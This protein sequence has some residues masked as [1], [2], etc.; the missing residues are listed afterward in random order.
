MHVNIDCRLK[1]ARIAAVIVF[2]RRV[3][4]VLKDHLRKLLITLMVKLQLHRIGRRR[5]N[6]V[7][8]HLV[9]FEVVF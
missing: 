9:R 2:K 6:V 3:L 7:D 5:A 4:G 1:K 8:I